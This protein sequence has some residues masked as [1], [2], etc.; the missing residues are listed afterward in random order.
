MLARKIVNNIKPEN[1][2]YSNSDRYV[3]LPSDLPN[4]KYSVHTDYTG[5]VEAVLEKGNGISPWLPTRKFPDRFSIIDY[6]MPQAPM[7]AYAFADSKFQKQDDERHFVLAR[8][9]LPNK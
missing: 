6:V 4:S 8:P 3:H 9:V 2:F 1:N 7:M 5:F